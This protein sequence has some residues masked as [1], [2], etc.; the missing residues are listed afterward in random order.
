MLNRRGFR[1]LVALAAI[2]LVAAM[3]PPVFSVIANV[4][5][6]TFRPSGG[7]FCK[8]S[9]SVIISSTTSGAS[10][11]Y[12]TDGSTPT[13]THGTA[14]ANGGTVSVGPGPKRTLKAIACKSGMTNSA[15]RSGSYEYDC[16][17]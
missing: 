16:G 4:A 2:G 7:R 12:T 5:T 1:A 17:Q 8:H 13:S 14:L 6:P 9:V 10:I 15:V 3:V 11:R